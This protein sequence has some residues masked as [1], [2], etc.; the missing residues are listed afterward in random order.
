MMIPEKQEILKPSPNDPPKMKAFKVFKNEFAEYTD[1]DKY[2]FKIVAVQPKKYRIGISYISS[3]DIIIGVLPRQF[4]PHIQRQ[5]YRSPL[6]LS[7]IIV[8][9][10]QERGWK[11]FKL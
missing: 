6:Y 10:A 9:I 7:R 3:P 11:E 8:K 2:V 1:G 4:S 5:Y